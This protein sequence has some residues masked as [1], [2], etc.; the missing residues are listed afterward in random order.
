M[1]LK[2]MLIGKMS[3]ESGYSEKALRRKIEDGVLIQGVHYVKSPDG[4][5][6][7]NVERFQEW[8]EGKR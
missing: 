8:L 2:Y 1:S 4:R 7:I 5:I 3:Q 6:N